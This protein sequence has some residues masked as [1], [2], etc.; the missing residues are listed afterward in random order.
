T[1][2]HKTYTMGKAD[3]HVLCGASLHADPGEYLVITGASGSG[4]STL[5]SILGAL[6]T[7]DRGTVTFQGRDVFRMPSAAQNAYRNRQVG[8]VFQFYHLF[9]ELNVLE[10]VLMPRLVMY[11]PVKWWSVRRQAK[12]D[13]AELL[14][15]VGLDHRAK[16][17]PKELSGGE[18][19]RVAV[20]RALINRP[21]LLLAD[22]PT[23]NLDESIGAGILSLLARLNGDGQT[24]VMVTHDPKVATY[25][26][27][28]LELREGVIHESSGLGSG[29]P[30]PAPVGREVVR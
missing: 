5:L 16:H 3:V 14:E 17:R 12:K 13:G 18:R 20:A 15:R 7:P 23:G 10:N 6:D 9:P 1:G 22:E 2:L 19:Q 4:K 8:F 29:R 26:H 28:G 11:G 25:A 27:R 24:I 30:V 21:A